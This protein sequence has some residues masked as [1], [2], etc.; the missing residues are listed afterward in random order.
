MNKFYCDYTEDTPEVVL[1][2]ENG[3]YTI[4]GRSLPENAVGFYEPIFEWFSNL[5]NANDVDNIVLDIKLDYFNTSSAKQITKL[6]LIVQKVSESK[7]IL[8][9]WHYF[10]DDTDIKMSGERF[11]RLID[12][13]INI[14]PYND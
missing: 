8:V 9:N 11:A 6:L 7:N 2:S 14:L 5:K 13:K 4:K 10:K 1:D 12:V 3:I